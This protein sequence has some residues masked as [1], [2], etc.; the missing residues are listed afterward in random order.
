MLILFALST[1]FYWITYFI[2]LDTLSSSSS[3]FDTV[4]FYFEQFC[5]FLVFVF[6]PWS[7][8]FSLLYGSFF[9]CSLMFFS[10]EFSLGNIHFIWDDVQF[11]DTGVVKNLC[12]KKVQ[13]QAQISS[14]TLLIYQ[15]S[16]KLFIYESQF[17]NS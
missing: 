12:C 16:D 1:E 3:S 6:P 8:S 2:L 10:L 13:A 7:Y 14:I 17:P 5:S 4:L 15:P 9:I 11:I